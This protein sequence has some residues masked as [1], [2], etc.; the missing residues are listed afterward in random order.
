MLV[1]K[2]C[3]RLQYMHTELQSMETFAAVVLWAILQYWYSTY[4]VKDW[5][6]MHINIRILG[7]PQSP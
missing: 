5:T 2:Q 1:H 4:L 6:R 3:I 7:A